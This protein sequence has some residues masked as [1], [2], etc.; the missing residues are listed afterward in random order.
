MAQTAIDEAL[1]VQIWERQA[2]DCAALAALGLHVVF[3]GVPSDAGGPDYQD[4]VFTSPGMG[5]L[6]SSRQSLPL[7]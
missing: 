2:F 3:R 1:V 7:A 6:H 5:M 4:V